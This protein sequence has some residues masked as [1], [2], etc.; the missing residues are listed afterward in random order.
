VLELIL[1][2]STGWG[3]WQN[4]QRVFLQYSQIAC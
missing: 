2:V 4:G 3:R 1:E